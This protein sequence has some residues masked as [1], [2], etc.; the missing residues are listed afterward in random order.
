MFVDVSP[1]DLDLYMGLANTTSERR[2]RTSNTT[3]ACDVRLHRLHQS[4]S[5]EKK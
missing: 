3:R 4:A 1:L 5:E 2:E